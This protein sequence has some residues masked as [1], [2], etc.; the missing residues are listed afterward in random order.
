MRTAAGVRWGQGLCGVRLCRSH[1]QGFRTHRQTKVTAGRAVPRSC[2]SPR[3]GAE[4]GAVAGYIVCRVH[5]GVTT[6]HQAFNRGT[7]EAS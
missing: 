5:R 6:W 3:E 7:G 1:R 4:G 2:M